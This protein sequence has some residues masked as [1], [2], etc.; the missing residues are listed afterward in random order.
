M[1]TKGLWAASKRVQGI[2]SNTFGSYNQFNSRYFF[3]DVWVS[4]QK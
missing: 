1:S 4:D 3:K 2:D